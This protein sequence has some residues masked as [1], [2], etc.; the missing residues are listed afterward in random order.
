[1]AES[2]K[3]VQR[4]TGRKKKS[5]GK[6]SSAVAETILAALAEAG[7][8]AYLAAQAV[9]NPKLFLALLG[10]VL[11]L[12]MTDANGGPPTIH[13]VRF[14]GENDPDVGIGRGF[15][16]ENDFGPG[17]DFGEENDFGEGGEA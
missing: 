6:T 14:S 9:E 5:S 10:R 13:V 12:Q 7:G 15:G 17:R 16:E 4:T 8:A 2:E 11:P 3:N 1:M